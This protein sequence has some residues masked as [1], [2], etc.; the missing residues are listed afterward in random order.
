ME[1]LTVAMK[2]LQDQAVMHDPTLEREKGDCA[3]FRERARVANEVAARTEEAERSDAFLNE[4]RA[5]KS[6]GARVGSLL[7]KRKMRVDEV[8]GDEVARSHPLS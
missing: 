5:H 7:F 8:R 4:L 2:Q 1:E 6:I 3:R